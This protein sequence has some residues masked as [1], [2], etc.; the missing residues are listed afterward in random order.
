[1]A[2][3]HSNG[4]KVFEEKYDEESNGAQTRIIF[5]KDRSSEQNRDKKKIDKKTETVKPVQSRLPP[6]A[7]KKGFLNYF[8]LSVLAV[9]LI[10]LVI[11]SLAFY[12]E[13]LS[14]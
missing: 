9:S 8:L 14:R 7:K 3:K 2:F 1:M 5:K 4:I 11:F 10:A 6:K 12:F 13:Y